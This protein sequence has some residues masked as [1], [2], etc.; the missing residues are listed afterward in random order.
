ML[1][2]IP[3]WGAEIKQLPVLPLLPAELSAAMPVKVKGWKLKQASAKNTYTK[4]IQTRATRVFE[5]EPKS[6]QETPL[7]VRVKLTDTGRFYPSIQHFSVLAK[8]QGKGAG[9]GPA[10]KRVAG[11][12]GSE[13]SFPDGRRQVRLLL[14]G[15]YIIEL[16]LPSGFRD[17]QLDLFLDAFDFSALKGKKGKP[18][19]RLPSTYTMRSIDELKPERNRSYQMAIITAEEVKEMLEQIL[20]VDPTIAE[21]GEGQ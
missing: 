18:V 2:P 9:A 13:Q 4:W 20:A 17:A 14:Q 10:R 1:A 5:S 16:L 8:Q 7:I 11:L 3:A 15:R 21:D 6:K 19:K 12:K